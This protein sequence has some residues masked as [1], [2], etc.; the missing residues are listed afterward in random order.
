MIYNNVFYHSHFNI[1]GGVETFLFELAKLAHKNKRDFTIVY[2]SGHP[3]QIERLKKYCRVYQLNEIEKPIKCKKAFF[4]YDIGA[5]DDFEAEEYIQIVHADFHSPCL[6]TWL[7]TCTSYND[8]RITKKYAV[9]KNSAKSFEEVTGEHVEVL[10]NPLVLEPEPRVM[11]LLSAQRL[12]GEKGGK[13]LER[14]VQ[15]LDYSGVPYVWHIFSDQRLS[16]KSPNIMYHEPTL[17]VRNWIKYADYTVLL[18]DTEGFPYTAYESLCLGT[19]LI[20]T[21][22]PMLPDLGANETN[23]FI[24]DFDMSNLDVQ[25]IYK[26]AGKFKFKYEQKPDGWL[27]LIQGESTYK[28]VPPKILKVKAIMNYYDIQFKR[29]VKKGEVFEVDEERASYL[30]EHKGVEYYKE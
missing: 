25:K 16:I 20:I 5:I 21:R 14:L 19:P 12:S 22:L 13:R 10:Y 1:I 9:S 8:P 15:E 7:R 6:Q 11:T 18:S 30:V 4:N 27:D 28:Y 2:K 26:K 17:T 29:D 3:K 23:S 24:L